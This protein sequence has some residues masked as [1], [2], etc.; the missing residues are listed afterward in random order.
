MD[1]LDDNDEIEIKGVCTHA[2]IF[3]LKAGRKVIPSKKRNSKSKGF[4][5][6]ADEDLE[7]ALQIAKDEDKRVD[8]GPIRI[9]NDTYVVHNNQMKLDHAVQLKNTSS[10]GGKAGAFIGCSEM[11]FIIALYEVNR[12]VASELVDGRVEY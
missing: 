12:K 8:S 7:N 5:A 9:G 11:S 3:D 1:K 10:R 2:C 4:P 6:I